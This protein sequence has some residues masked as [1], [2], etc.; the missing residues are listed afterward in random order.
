M[1]EPSG[2][3]WRER[4]KRKHE[5]THFQNFNQHHAVVIA[6]LVWLNINVKPRTPWD[7]VYENP[8]SRL[9]WSGAGYN[10]IYAK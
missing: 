5:R 4:R 3:G 9:E 7:A 6:S 1:K 2:S 10:G 8:N